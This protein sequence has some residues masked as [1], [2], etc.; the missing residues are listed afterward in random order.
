MRRIPRSPWSTSS[1]RV[2]YVDHRGVLRDVLQ[3]VTQHGVSVSS[4]DVDREASADGR[5]ALTLYVD[6]KASST[7][8]AAAVEHLD[9]VLSVRAGEPSDD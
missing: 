2:I 6:G 1:L 3:E 8:L 5:V 7:T 4:V 9:G